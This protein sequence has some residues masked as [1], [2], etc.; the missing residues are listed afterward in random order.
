MYFHQLLTAFLYL[1]FYQYEQAFITRICRPPSPTPT[2]K[3][4]LLGVGS[5]LRMCVWR[6]SNVFRKKFLWVFKVN[7]TFFYFALSDVT[8]KTT[9]QQH[10]SINPINYDTATH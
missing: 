6:F 5:I 8:E 2:Q 1:A 4:K 10:Y 9:Y 7:L 3:R